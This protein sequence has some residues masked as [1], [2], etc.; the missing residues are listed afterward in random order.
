MPFKRGLFLKMEYECNVIPV[1]LEYYSNQTGL[2]NFL[3]VKP[4]K[5]KNEQ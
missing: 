2:V 3:K 4:S 1:P 5:S